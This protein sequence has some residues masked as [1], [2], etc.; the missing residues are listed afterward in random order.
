MRL[1]IHKKIIRDDI[2]MINDKYYRKLSIFKKTDNKWRLKSS[3]SRKDKLM[4]HLQLLERHH[5]S[6]N[7]DQNWHQRLKLGCYLHKAVQMGY[8][9]L[10]R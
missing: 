4:I 2:Y 9:H 10:K 3:G 5:S 7:A 8:L 1:L 6:Y